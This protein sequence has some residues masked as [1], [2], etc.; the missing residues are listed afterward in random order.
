ML[1]AAPSVRVAI[2]GR[3]RRERQEALEVVFRCVWG[4]RAHSNSGRDKTKTEPPRRCFC[5]VAC[6]PC[7]VEQPNCPVR[8]LPHAVQHCLARCSPSCPVHSLDRV[9]DVVLTIGHQNPSSL[10]AASNV[11]LISVLTDNKFDAH[12]A[13]SDCKSGHP[14]QGSSDTPTYFSAA[15]CSSFPAISLTRSCERRDK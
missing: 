12:F 10:S 9:R 3:A 7:R 11:T 1:S 4:V 8:F 2:T 14:A 5:S 6:L 15:R 13:V